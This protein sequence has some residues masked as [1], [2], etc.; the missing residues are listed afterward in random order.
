MTRRNVQSENRKILDVASLIQ[1]PHM[2]VC[3]MLFF[4]WM[5]SLRA[6]PR[7]SGCTT[8]GALNASVHQQTH[9]GEVIFH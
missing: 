6:T 2:R 5:A 1:R 9:R 3:F 4:G 7:V 8:F